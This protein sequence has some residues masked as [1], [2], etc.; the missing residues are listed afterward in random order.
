MPR[1][2]KSQLPG[3]GAAMPN[4]VGAVCDMFIQ[5][6]RAGAMAASRSAAASVDEDGPESGDIDGW[7]GDADGW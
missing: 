1:P 6:G 5:G 4:S 2:S 7:L 3:M